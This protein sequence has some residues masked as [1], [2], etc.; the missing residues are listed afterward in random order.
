MTTTRKTANAAKAPAKKSGSFSSEERAAMREAAKEARR[1]KD[2]DFE[3]EVLAKIAAMKEPDRAMATRIHA[4]V[5]AAAPELEAKTWYGMPA[6]GKDGKTVLF[7]QDAGKFK[8]RYSTLGF[9]D[10]A[11]LDDGNF[12][13]NAYALTKLTAADEAKIAALIKRAVG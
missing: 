7:F 2:F 11:Q 3:G 8:T 12:W 6:Y 1:A 5:K 4:I 10:K 13:P 9:S